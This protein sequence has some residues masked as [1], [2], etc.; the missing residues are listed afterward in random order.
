MPNGGG[1]PYRLEPRPP[2]PPG[3]EQRPSPSPCHTSDSDV[4]YAHKIAFKHL[5]RRHFRRW[6]RVMP[7]PRLRRYE[8]LL[9]A[10]RLLPAVGAVDI[11]PLVSA[12]AAFL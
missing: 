12:I 7:I 1:P 11:R 6:R 3:T 5:R 2:R 9:L 4:T 10:N 8:L